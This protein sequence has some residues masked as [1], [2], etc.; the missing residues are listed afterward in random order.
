MQLIVFI[1][2]QGCGKST[3]YLR[4]LV[5]THIR[6][7]L[8]M[9]RTRHREMLL[10]NACIEAKQPIVIDNTNPTVEERSR[11]IAPARTAGFGVV[12]YYFQSLIEDCKRRNMQREERRVVPLAGLL[13]TYTRLTVPTHKEGFD[14]LK[15]V[16][17]DEAGQFVL[18]EW[19]NEVR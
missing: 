14:E 8:D 9:L 12:G 13:G 16:R 7:N 19:S 15:Y 3:F 10:F 18:E 1:G 6:L 17:I 4:H 5:D 2:L 11:Y